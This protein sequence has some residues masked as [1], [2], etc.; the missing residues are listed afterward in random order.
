MAPCPAEIMEKARMPQTLPWTCSRTQQ[1]IKK[2]GEEGGER[3]KKVCSYKTN[4]PSLLSCEPAEFAVGLCK[5]SHCA[6]VER[7]ALYGE[8]SMPLEF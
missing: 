8:L 1:K 2:M 4:S 3:A 6:G 7:A 5:R